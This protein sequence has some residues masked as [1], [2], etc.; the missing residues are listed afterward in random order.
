MPV[1]LPYIYLPS[2]LWRI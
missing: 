1:S 2:I